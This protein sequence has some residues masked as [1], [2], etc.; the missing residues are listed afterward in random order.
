[1]STKTIDY[2]FTDKIQDFGEKIEGAKKDTWQSKLGNV[3]LESITEKKNMVIDN[4][5][6]KPDYKELVSSGVDNNDAA[7]IFVAREEVKRLLR[8]YKKRTLDSIKT[9]IQPI[10]DAMKTITKSGEIKKYFEAVQGGE[11][12]KKKVKL[13]TTLGFP[14]VDVS[15]N[16]FSYDIKDFGKYFIVKGRYII[17]KNYDSFE[18]AAIA[19]SLIMNKR[20]E[21]E[22]S[23][24]LKVYSWKSNASNWI[25]GKKIGA[26]K[27]IE[28]KSG[29]KTSKDA[30]Q[31]L[32]EN[33][34][35]LVEQLQKLKQIPDERRAEN[36]ERLGK[37]HTGGKD[38]TPETFQEKFGFRGVQF[39][40]YVEGAKRQIDLNESFNA[41]VDLANILNIPTEAISLNGELGLAFGA[42]GS[43]MFSAHYEPGQIVINLTKKRGAGS[44]A[45]EWFHAIDNYF[46]KQLGS[47]N[48]ITNNPT[49]T[50]DPQPGGI[51]SEKNPVPINYNQARKEAVDAFKNLTDT[52]KQKTGL[53][54]RGKNLDNRKTKD[55]WGTIIE[56][57]ARSFESYVVDRLEAEGIQNDFLANFKTTSEYVRDTD[58]NL[59]VEND[60]PYPLE[61]ER[62]VINEAFDNL[63]QTLE[64]KQT[65]KG[66][67]LY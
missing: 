55:Y 61:S 8:K 39:G 12:I 24:K 9:D 47:T 60:Y 28:I 15:P 23:E 7:Y 41:L 18:D 43:G 13:L 62:K 11:T 5:I 3:N 50:I 25:I 21:S 34:E 42:R 10:L 6:P 22:K 52:V 17:S 32:K 2:K 64:T 26:G 29:F 63:F 31:Y 56:I 66:T 27:Y 48:Y 33:S 36:R 46:G 65:E 30:N 59:D 16:I 4:I 37:D 45:H 44:L 38:V 14:T 1:M 67:A 19:L 54:A 58:V 51:Y 20:N 40:N 35:E 57:G 49:G 53:Q